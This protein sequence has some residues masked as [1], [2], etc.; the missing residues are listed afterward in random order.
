MTTRIVLMLTVCLACRPGTAHAQDDP[1]VG[2]VMGYP[3]N[4]GVLW[5]VTDRIAI[6]PEINFFR[7]TISTEGSGIL[8]PL[9]DTL[10]TRS[11]TPGVS[12]LIYLDGVQPLRTYVSPR[13]AVSNL[14]TSD[15]PLG[16]SRPDTNSYLVGGSLGAQYRAA[17]R[18]AL[19]GE[20]GVEYRRSEN[21]RAI[22]PGTTA[23]SR[24]TSVGTRSGVG[25]VV[26][27]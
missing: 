24:T 25:I 13:F 22:V 9:S 7:T 5:H 21:E 26:Y 8:E 18:F 1:K 12:A 27:F 11:I 14:H 16:T 2:A 4:V 15:D 6:R 23:T 17:T 19:F 20:V 3:T 10:T